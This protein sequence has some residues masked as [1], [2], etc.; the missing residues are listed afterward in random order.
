[1]SRA[2][3]RDPLGSGPLSDVSWVTLGKSKTLNLLKPGSLI[4]E[5]RIPTDLPLRRILGVNARSAVI[6]NKGCL[7]LSRDI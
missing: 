2:P 1:M 4:S 3:A 7:L 6:P 5:M